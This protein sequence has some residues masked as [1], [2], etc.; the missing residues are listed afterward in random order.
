MTGILPIEPASQRSNIIA[1]SVTPKSP[2]Q[3]FQVGIA[4]LVAYGA[5]EHR[6]RM[7]PLSKPEVGYRGVV[8]RGAII[9]LRSYRFQAVIK[10]VFLIPCSKQTDTQLVMCEGV[11]CIVREN[12]SIP[13]NCDLGFIVG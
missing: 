11:V 5:T 3:L 1:D 2:I 12:F 8:H 7:T 6:L 13:V 10:P 9:R 4:G